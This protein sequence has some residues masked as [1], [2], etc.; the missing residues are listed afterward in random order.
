MPDDGLRRTWISR[1]CRDGRPR[2]PPEGWRLLGRPR[3]RDRLGYRSL[4]TPLERA[5]RHRSPCCDLP[6]LLDVGRLR[7][8]S[9]DRRGD[10]PLR[11]RPGA[12]HGVG[13]R[14][15]LVLGRLVGVADLH[16]RPLRIP[17]F[18]A[19]AAR[20][21]GPR[22]PETELPVGAPVDV[23][24]ERPLVSAPDCLGGKAPDHDLDRRA[25]RPLRAGFARGLSHGKCGF[26]IEPQIH[27]PAH[28]VGANRS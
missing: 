15:P 28:L 13:G 12:P 6:P 7:V 26:Q 8:P 27:L 21:R 1:R 25:R 19:I 2:R 17:K 10:L 18:D 3:R 24:D 22:R 9:G 23:V 20:P 11:W 14:V 4:S 16:E 5:R